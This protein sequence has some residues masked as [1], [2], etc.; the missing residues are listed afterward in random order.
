M[1]VVSEG[2]FGFLRRGPESGTGDDAKAF[3]AHHTA[4]RAALAHLD[5]LL[6]F[7]RNMGAAATEAE[8]ARLMVVEAREALA[9]F[10]EDDADAGEEQC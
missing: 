3:I 1:E 4:C 7:A 9:Q 6:K 8:E 2:Y 5:A 10:R